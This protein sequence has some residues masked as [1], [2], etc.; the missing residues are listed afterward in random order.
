M[1]TETNDIESQ[2]FLGV[3]AGLLRSIEKTLGSGSPHLFDRNVET[4]GAVPTT[5]NDPHSLRVSEL[6]NISSRH[7]RWHLS[8]AFLQ[9]PGSCTFTHHLPSLGMPVPLRLIDCT[10]NGTHA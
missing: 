9:G 4:G 1:I 8:H 10:A 7:V 6:M 5:V 2:S 3:A